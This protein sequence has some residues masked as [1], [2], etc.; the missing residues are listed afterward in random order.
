MSLASDWA[1]AVATEDTKV[2]NAEAQRPPDCVVG[3]LSA[4][5]TR[6]GGLYLNKEA[7]LSAAEA[8][9]LGQWIIATFG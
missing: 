3:A 5:V 4:T 8:L 7:T 6:D 1:A 2:R 9:T